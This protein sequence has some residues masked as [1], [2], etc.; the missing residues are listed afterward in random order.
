MIIEQHV[1]KVSLRELGGRLQQHNLIITT[2]I[3]QRRARQFESR[4]G[5]AFHLARVPA[6]A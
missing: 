5:W 2:T 1:K 6:S 3:C 4:P